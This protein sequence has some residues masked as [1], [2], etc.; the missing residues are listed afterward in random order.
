MNL[1]HREP[2]LFARE[3]IDK[4]ENRAIILCE[5][6]MVPTL[7]MF[8]EAAAQSSAAFASPQNDGIPIGFLVSCRDVERL[9]LPVGTCFHMKVF[10]EIDLGRIKKFFFEATGFSEKSICA[11]GSITMMIPG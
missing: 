2:L 6:E 11:S 7:P 8:I 1:P 10:R 4:R 3:V 5:F 9:A